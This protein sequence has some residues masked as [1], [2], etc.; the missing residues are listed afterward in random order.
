MKDR[1]DGEEQL[2][3]TDTVGRSKS[4]VSKIRKLW[5]SFLDASARLFGLR[6]QSAAASSWESHSLHLRSHISSLQ[7]N[8]SRLQKKLE[9][10]RWDD[11]HCFS[12][13]SRLWGWE[14]VM[15]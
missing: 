12:F 1:K 3:R 13:I 15:F 8:N 11:L 4:S 6:A 5:R 14:R 10:G 9:Y 2:I 7:I